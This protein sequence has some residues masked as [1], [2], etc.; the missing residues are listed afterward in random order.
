MLNTIDTMPCR[1]RCLASLFAVALMLAACGEGSTDDGGAS[2]AA[3]NENQDADPRVTYEIGRDMADG[4]FFEVTLDPKRQLQEITMVYDGEYTVPAMDAQGKPRKSD[5]GKPYYKDGIYAH[6][7]VVGANGT[8]DEVSVPKF[9]DSDE[10]DNWHD[11]KPLSGDKLRVE[12]SY[13]DEY[14]NDPAVIAAH[15]KVRMTRIIV[16]YQDPP[17][18]TFQTFDYDLGTELKSNAEIPAGGEFG[19][20]FDGKKTVYRVDVRWGDARPRAADGTYVPGRANGYIT[21]DGFTSDRR[22]VAEIETQA[23]AVSNAAPLADGNHR[24]TVHMNND[25]GR[26]HWIKVFYR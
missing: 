17:G 9:V 11:L 10:T 22:N 20:D 5:E 6:G 4:D 16:Q 24:V 26:V 18:L 19:I 3:I 15:T 1:S 25:N 7:F 23:F 12:F 21:V 13:A 8:R 2:A 14:R